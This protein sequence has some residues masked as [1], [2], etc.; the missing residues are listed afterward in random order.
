MAMA[1]W[2]AKFGTARWRALLAGARWLFKQG[3]DRLE[4]N[5]TPDERRELWQLLRKSRGRRYNLS[6]REQDRFKELVRQG[7]FGRD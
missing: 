3:R 5:L 1:G 7:V 2:A 6:E 4:R